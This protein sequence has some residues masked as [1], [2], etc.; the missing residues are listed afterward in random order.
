MN[1]LALGLGLVY[2]ASCI[3]V[4]VIPTATLFGLIYFI[5]SK[6]FLSSKKNDDDYQEIVM[7]NRQA[8][9]SILPQISFSP[10]D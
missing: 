5:V 1:V 8:R 2:L 4:I 6:Y 3:L 10:N 7:R 9:N